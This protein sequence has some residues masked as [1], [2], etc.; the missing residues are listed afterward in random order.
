MPFSLH[1]FFLRLNVLHPDI[2]GHLLNMYNITNQ[3]YKLFKKGILQ[4]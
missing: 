2:S 1:I 3:S 4:Y